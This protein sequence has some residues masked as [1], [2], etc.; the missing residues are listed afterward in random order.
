MYLA[1]QT[2]THTHR[3]MS[4]GRFLLFNWRLISHYITLHVGSV[5]KYLN[6]LVCVCVC[7]TGSTA[8]QW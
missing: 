2:D 8:S 3:H 7:S 5:K 4:E 1:L 6:N